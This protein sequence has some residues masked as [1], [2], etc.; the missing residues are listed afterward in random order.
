MALE[1]WRKQYLTSRCYKFKG[2]AKYHTAVHAKRNDGV[3]HRWRQQL[4]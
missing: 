2:K 3:N 1:K 4:F